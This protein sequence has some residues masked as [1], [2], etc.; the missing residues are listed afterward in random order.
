MPT[1]IALLPRCRC[2]RRTATR[3]AALPPFLVAHSVGTSVFCDPLF[4]WYS[5]GRWILLLV[6]P[7]VGAYFPICKTHQ[8]GTSSGCRTGFQSLPV[9]SYGGSLSYPAREKSC[10]STY[11]PRKNTTQNTITQLIHQQDEPCHPYPS[12]F[13]LSPMTVHQCCPQIIVLLLPHKCAQVASHR[14]CTCRRWFSCC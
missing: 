8:N 14:A 7:E 1:A 11:L 13:P 5:A 9:P 3:V 2:C 6:Q 4:L 10:V 12:G